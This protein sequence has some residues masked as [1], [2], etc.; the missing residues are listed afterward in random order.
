MSDA[1]KDFHLSPAVHEYLVAHGTPP[2]AIAAELIEAT[3]K[4]GGVSIM[5]VAPEQG[6][7]MTLFT[8]AIGAR[9][10]IEIG[11]FT[12]L[13]ALS[14]ARGLP[15]DGRLICCDVSD[16]WA[17]VGQPF[18]EKAGVADR[19]ELRIA[20]AIETLRALTPEPSVGLAFIDA[21]KTGYVD[22]YEALLPRM[23]A[24]GVILVDNV[25][26]SGKVA[27]PTADDDQT[28]AIR[29]FNDHVAADERVE[30]VMLPIA[31]GLTFVRRR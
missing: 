23:R 11:T 24:G 20:P 22:Y 15:D 30:K 6:A 13:S 16:E 27:D 17:R 4:L 2:D 10:A 7:F 9:R 29:R 8:R 18:W 28:G 3:R 12:G 19:I 5:Q 26:W 31:D 1:P 14:I 25:L 21:D